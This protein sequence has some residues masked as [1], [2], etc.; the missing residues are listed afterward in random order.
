LRT[1]LITVS[2]WEGKKKKKKKRREREILDC[3]TIKSCDA[4]C[5][6][7]P[8][9]VSV[10]ERVPH[11]VECTSISYLYL[12]RMRALSWAERSRIDGIRA[13]FLA[14]VLRPTVDPAVRGLVVA[15][16]ALG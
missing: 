4:G 16:L 12:F 15:R 13:L 9:S 6:S 10:I 11:G 3:V 1:K 8:V 2:L 7:T 5:G 14:E